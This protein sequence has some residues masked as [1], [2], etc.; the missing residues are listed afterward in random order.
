[1]TTLYLLRHAHS[2]ANE[3]GILAGRLEGVR[4]SDEGER[5]ARELA[6]YLAKIPL[7]HIYSSPLERC[8]QTVE[9]FARRKKVRVVSEPGIQEMDYG[10]WSGEKLSSLSKKPLWRTIKKNPMRVRFPEGES[11]EEAAERLEKALIR[12]A[13]K[14]PKKK[15]LLVTHGDIIKMAIQKTLQGDMNKFQR[16]VVDP[17]SLTVLE[18]DSKTRFL[19]S[20]NQKIV[21]QRR[22]QKSLRKRATLGGGSNV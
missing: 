12:I 7:T 15:V 10:K 9:S 13:K 18:W 8:L 3:K 17:A 14:H 1:M 20:A 16:I 19:L 21:T 6:A 22:K 2:I 4:L 5:Q 11:F